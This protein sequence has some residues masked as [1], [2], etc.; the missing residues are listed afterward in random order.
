[1]LRE[2]PSLG[3][4]LDLPSP[5]Q[6]WCYVAHALFSHDLPS[7]QVPLASPPTCASFST[8]L[9]TP[10]AI[11]VSLY[12][13]DPPPTHPIIQPALRL[14]TIL[15]KESRHSTIG[16]EL[17]YLLSETAWRNEVTAAFGKRR[18]LAIYF[19]TRVKNAMFTADW[20]WNHMVCAVA[21][22]SVKN[23]AYSIFTWKD[24]VYWQKRRM[25]LQFWIVRLYNSWPWLLDTRCTTC[26]S[27]T[28]FITSPRKKQQV[29]TH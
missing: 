28:D 26:S 9:L 29:Q 3:T 13:N 22:W 1:M 5:F 12:K 6:W 27:K 15:C 10:I 19:L 17:Q 11:S 8:L 7:N 23:W 16:R 14:T 25:K 18:H 24:Y 21:N 20:D 4:L 2:L